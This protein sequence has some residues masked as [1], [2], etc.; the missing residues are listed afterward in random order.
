MTPE[1]RDAIESARSGR[2]DSL[3]LHRA[4]PQPRY[5]FEFIRQVVLSV[6]QELPSEM[7]LGELAEELFIANNQT[8]HP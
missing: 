2:V 3:V 7:T 5:S 6:V 1:I 4:V 8:R